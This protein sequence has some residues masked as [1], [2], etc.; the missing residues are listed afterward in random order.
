MHLKNAR[1]HSSGVSN[2]DFR[3]KGL[4]PTSKEFMGFSLRS[5]THCLGSRSY[6]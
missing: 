4:L 1:I 6:S 3:T 5:I 2:L